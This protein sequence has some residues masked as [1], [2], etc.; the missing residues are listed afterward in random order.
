M[1]KMTENQL[2]NDDQLLLQKLDDEIKELQKRYINKI[3]EIEALK[4]KLKYDYFF[5]W[6]CGRKVNYKYRN[7]IRYAYCSFCNVY[8]WESTKSLKNRS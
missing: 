2:L 4:A 3:D 7:T 1:K 6:N 8:N 5:C